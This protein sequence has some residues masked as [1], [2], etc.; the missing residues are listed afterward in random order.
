MIE[1]RTLANFEK[2]N[3]SVITVYSNKLVLGMLIFIKGG[4]PEKNRRNIG[5]SQLHVQTQLTY[6]A[7]SG[8]RTREKSALAA[9]S[10]K[11]PFKFKLNGLEQTNRQN[12]TE[13]F[14]LFAP[15]E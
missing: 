1:Q 15:V 3:G 10:P 11:L 4:K 5:E 14:K 2:K 13:G 6:G 12:F 7:Q 8:N 9:T